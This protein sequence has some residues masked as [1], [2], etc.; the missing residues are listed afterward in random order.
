MLTKTTLIIIIQYYRNNKQK[1][2][3]DEVKNDRRNLARYETKI[4]K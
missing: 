2:L 1:Y 3:N 4:Q